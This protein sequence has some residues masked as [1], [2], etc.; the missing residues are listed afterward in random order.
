ME[1]VCALVIVDTKNDIARE[2]SIEIS[3]DFISQYQ[4][5]LI[6]LSY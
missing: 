2:T 6:S 1:Y 3:L 4:N 5:L